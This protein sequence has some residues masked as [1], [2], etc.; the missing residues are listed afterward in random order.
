M[1]YHYQLAIMTSPAYKEL[2]KKYKEMKDQNRKEKD[3]KM[4]VSRLLFFR[5]CMRKKRS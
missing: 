5:F 1:E 2:H 4:K 3:M